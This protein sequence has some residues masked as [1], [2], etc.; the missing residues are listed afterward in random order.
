MNKLIVSAFVLT[1]ATG[2]GAYIFNATMDNKVYAYSGNGYNGG[3]NMRQGMQD[4]ANILGISTEELTRLRDSGKTMLEIAKDKGISED[5]FHQKVQ[6]AAVARWKT[7]GFTDQEIQE[8][9]TQMKERQ[10]NCD[11]TPKNN[12]MMGRGQGRGM[13]R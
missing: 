12:G 1:I 11:G 2:I 6:E 3:N 5:T 13:N 4:K 7:K 9:L 8:R 10:D